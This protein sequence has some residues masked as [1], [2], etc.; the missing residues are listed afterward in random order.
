MGVLDT[1]VVVVQLLRERGLQGSSDEVSI[2]KTHLRDLWAVRSN[3]K[4]GSVLW[5]RRHGQCLTVV[6]RLRASDARAL[7]LHALREAGRMFKGSVLSSWRPGVLLA[8]GLLGEPLDTMDSLGPKVVQATWFHATALAAKLMAKDVP[9]A[10]AGDAESNSP[11][12]ETDASDSSSSTSSSSTS[13][14]TASPASMACSHSQPS[15]DG[16]DEGCDLSPA[17]EC[18]YSAP[19]PSAPVDPANDGKRARI[20]PAVVLSSSSSGVC[21]GEKQGGGA[22]AHAC[23][24][25]ERRSCEQKAMIAKMMKMTRARPHRVLGVAVGASV[26]DAR[27]RYLEIIRLIHPDKCDLPKAT[28]AFRV[29]HSAFERTQKMRR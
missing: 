28:E 3:S 29:V 15:D 19:G 10:P 27:K 7:S 14:P 18:S 13:D 26:S 17:G 8:L 25:A 23:A 2:A 1:P 21:D 11:R 24:P 12:A 4:G 6:A 16:Q 22:Q 20:D 9:C 5:R